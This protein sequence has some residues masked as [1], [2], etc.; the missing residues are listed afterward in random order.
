MA[1]ALPIRMA[2]PDDVDAIVAIAT[3]AYAIYVARI[4]KKPAPMVADFAALVVDGTVR[5]LAGEDGAVAG[6]VVF[7]PR[8]ESVHLENIAVAPER[9]GEGVGRR[10]IDFV[11][12]WARANGF[13]A[14]ELYTNEKM[15]ENIALYPRLGYVETHRAEED[16]FRRVFFRKAIAVR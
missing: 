10:L 3:A 13:A 4:G 7:Y 15:T 11:E 1:P 9:Q 5:V 2:G 16:G 8:G 14:V 6:Y 12:A